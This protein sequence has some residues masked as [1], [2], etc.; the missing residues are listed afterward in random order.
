MHAPPTQP[1]RPIARVLGKHARI[2]G[3]SCCN[4]TTAKNTRSSVIESQLKSCTMLGC[5][6]TGCAF[7]LMMSLA[8]TSQVSRIFVL[9]STQLLILIHSTATR[10]T[11]QSSTHCLIEG[12][13]RSLR[14][15]IVSL[16]V[17][18]FAMPPSILTQCESPLYLAR[19]LA[20][21]PSFFRK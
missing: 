17:A 2:V 4:C 16:T 6:T 12:F 21:F 3:S 18:S 7:P 5:P 8:N 9:S 11:K 14:R 15:Y 13:G 1:P 20:R 19:R 10:H